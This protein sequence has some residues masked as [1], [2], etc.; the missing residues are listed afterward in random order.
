MLFLVLGLCLS[1]TQSARP[2]LHWGR[3]PLRHSSHVPSCGACLL[4]PAWSRALLLFRPQSSHHFGFSDRLWGFPG[5]S[6]IKHL[7]AVQETQVQSLGRE[8]PLEKEMATHSSI[9]AW[10]IPW[11]GSLVGCS[12]GGHKQ[13]DMTW[14][15]NNKHRF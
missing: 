15:L 1:P 8:D 5:G 2:L 14:R 9:L 4:L 7:P 3:V 6:V 13:L 11:T 10:E 12:P